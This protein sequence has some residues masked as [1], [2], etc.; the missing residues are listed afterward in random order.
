MSYYLILNYSK[1]FDYDD[2][3]AEQQAIVD[4]FPEQ[5]NRAQTA[6]VKKYLLEAIERTFEGTGIQHKQNEWVAGDLYMVE[7]YKVAIDVT[8]DAQEMLAEGRQIS[9]LVMQR[10]LP[11]LDNLDPFYDRTY[12][13]VRSAKLSQDLQG[14]KLVQYNG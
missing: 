14:H 9:A 11:N 2:L 5:L 10:Y 8:E 4:G 6:Q 12:S 7:H 3:T 1:V 13:E